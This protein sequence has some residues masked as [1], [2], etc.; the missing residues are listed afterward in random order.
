MYKK[1]IVCGPI[2]PYISCTAKIYNLNFDLVS[3]SSSIID[4]SLHKNDIS[5]LIRK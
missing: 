1:S 3:I 4:E 5:S 2:A